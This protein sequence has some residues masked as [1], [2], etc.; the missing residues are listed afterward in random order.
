[1]AGQNTQTKC[2][3]LVFEID[4]TNKYFCTARKRSC[5]AV[6]VSSGDVRTGPAV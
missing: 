4:I 5:E 2:P 1:M 6:C 3:N